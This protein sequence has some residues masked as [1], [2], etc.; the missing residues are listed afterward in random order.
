MGNRRKPFVIF[1]SFNSLSAVI[2]LLCGTLFELPAPCFMTAYVMLAIS[3]GLSP[4]T[5]SF[6]KELNHE[7][8]AGLSVGTQNTATY[9]SVA[10]SA[11]LIGLILDMFKSETRISSSGI[12]IYP[13]M[14]YVTIFATMLIFAIISVVAA[15]KTEENN[16]KI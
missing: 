12:R 4:V 16:V 2:L 3:A 1:A 5:V 14:A 13:P 7:D 9:L 6:I 8:A 15:F 10:I 11:S